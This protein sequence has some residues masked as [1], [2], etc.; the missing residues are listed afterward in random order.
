MGTQPVTPDDLRAERARAG[1]L[2]YEIAPKVGLNPHR[3]GE[4]FN[5]KAPL[6]PVLAER[7]LRA[8]DELRKNKA[9]P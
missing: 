7:V 2:L 5:G 8:I 1:V 4:V 9:A 3:L 6:T